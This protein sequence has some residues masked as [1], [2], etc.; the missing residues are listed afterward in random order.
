MQHIPIPLSHSPF[1]AFPPFLC[2][3]APSRGRDP[4]WIFPTQTCLTGSPL[5]LR[6]FAEGEGKVAGDDPLL[7]TPRLAGP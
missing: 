2:P 6:F 3:C 5:K 1:F 7:Q 4:R